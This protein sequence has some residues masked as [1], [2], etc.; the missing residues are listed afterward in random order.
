[1]VWGYCH[2]SVQ[3]SDSWLG[4]MSQPVT[5]PDFD[6]DALIDLDAAQSVL[7]G[8]TVVTQP[9]DPES[10]ADAPT[11]LVVAVGIDLA[12]YYGMERV[13]ET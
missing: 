11:G 13:I 10:L 8:L 7:D 6:P 12:G 3:V 2:A 5:R 9:A 4:G 1:M